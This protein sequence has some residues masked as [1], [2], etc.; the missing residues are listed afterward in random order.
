MFNT[1][2]VVDNNIWNIFSYSLYLYIGM[3]QDYYVIN[4]IKS[5][6]VKILITINRIQ[7][8]CFCLHNIC[9]YCVYLL[10]I[11]KYTHACISENN[12]VYTLNIFI[13]NINYMNINK[14]MEIFSKHILYV[15]LYIQ[16]KYTQNTHI[17]CKQNIYFVC[18]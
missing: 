10:C 8:K 18:D 2:H 7:N 11:Y 3:L 13:Y 12:Y 14:D 1:L 5:S 16:N 9:V 6:A 4:E 15:Y 17:L